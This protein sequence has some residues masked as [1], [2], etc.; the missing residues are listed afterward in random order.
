MKSILFILLK[1]LVVI[2]IIGFA[3]EFISLL[4]FKVP[5][6]VRGFIAGFVSLLLLTILINKRKE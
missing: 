4:N 6:F 2:I 1:C 5:Y 3:F